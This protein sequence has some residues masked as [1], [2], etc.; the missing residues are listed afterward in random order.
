MIALN[1]VVKPLPGCVQSKH[2]SRL[3]GAQREVDLA[4]FKFLIQRIHKIKAAQAQLSDVQ[5]SRITV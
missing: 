5:G 3:L 4:Q 1:A 2:V